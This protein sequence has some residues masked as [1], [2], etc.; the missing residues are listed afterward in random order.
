MD[1]TELE[2]QVP[3]SFICLGRSKEQDGAV[4]Q[5]AK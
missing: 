2:K 4:N 1:E 5:K 3:I